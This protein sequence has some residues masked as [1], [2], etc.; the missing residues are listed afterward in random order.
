[1]WHLQDSRRG[2][3]LQK[4][5]KRGEI[6][7]EPAK[8]QT[9]L[10]FS[11]SGLVGPWLCCFMTSPPSNAR[12]E[13]SLASS[14]GEG[15]KSRRR[16]LN[17]RRNLVP[18]NLPQ[19]SKYLQQLASKILFWSFPNADFFQ[20]RIWVMAKVLANTISPGPLNWK[21]SSDM[22]LLLSD[23]LPSNYGNFCDISWISQIKID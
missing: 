6:Q 21:D 5:S 8:Y 22:S 1:M 7:R 13:C 14:R 19:K 17:Y 11:G 12:L 16:K 15:D 18:T 20:Q 10:C 3:S 9:Q 23:N 2:V 4:H